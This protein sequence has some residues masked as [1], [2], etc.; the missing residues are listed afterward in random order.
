MPSIGTLP[1]YIEELVL[2]VFASGTFG[3]LLFLL[4]LGLVVE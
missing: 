3:L 2:A 1:C 4:L